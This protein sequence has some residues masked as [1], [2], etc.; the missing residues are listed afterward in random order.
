M[1]TLKAKVN[2]VW[3]PVAGNPQSAADLARWNSAW[4]QV[5]LSG[6]SNQVVTATTATVLTGNTVVVTLVAGRR[7][8]IRILTSNSYAS[9]AGE[10]WG[11]SPYLD[12]TALTTSY[13]SVDVGNNY[14][15]PGVA[16]EAV[17]TTTSGQHTIDI[18]A[19]RVNATGGSMQARFQFLLTDLGPV[20][21]AAIAPPAA[22]PRVVASGNALGI[23]AVGS[24]PA[25]LAP[26]TVTN[27]VEF[28][29]T[30]PLSFFAP[31]GRRYRINFQVRAMTP[32]AG[33][34]TQSFYLRD[35]GSAYRG[36]VPGGDP[37]VYVQANY[38]A[39]MFQW[40]MDGDNLQHSID[41]ACVGVGMSLFRDY[42]VFN[43]EDVGP[44]SSPA[45]PIPET[46]PPWTQ[47]TLENGWLNYLGG[48]PVAAYRKIGDEVSLRGLIRAGTTGTVAAF[49]LPVGFRPPL[50]AGNAQ[51]FPLAA[52]DAFGMARVSGAG[53]VQI[54]SVTNNSWVDLSAV[55]F[56]TTAA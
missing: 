7:Y 21:Q 20:S 36:W 45:L 27:G 35:N 50:A 43:I 9:T 33:A 19:W 28:V 41:V 12:G 37:Y 48:Y 56:S 10:T 31:A 26:A 29:I 14:L 55:R 52:N 13:Y 51:H 25:P 3:T 42:G 6:S 15:S 16:S 8:S 49:T 44:N 11:V 54:A 5:A 4:G 22:S 1:G 23:I 38:S 47:A 40:G 17:F 32:T 46:P 53:A 30:N 39:A 24:F 2:G 18:R 34:G